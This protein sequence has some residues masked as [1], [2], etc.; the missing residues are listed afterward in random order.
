MPTD[1]R[2]AI[3]PYTKLAIELGPLV[4]FFVTQRR[5]DLIVATGVFMV[6]MTISVVAS[7]K[8]EKRW[9]V[10][11]VITLAFVLVLGALTLA[12]GEGTFI[13]V[14]PTF[15]N[16]TFA[17][18]LLGGLA[19]GK[20][21][22][23]IVFSEAFELSDEGWR[24]LTVRFGLFFVG[25][26]ILNEIVWRNFSDDGWTNFKVFG[27]IPLTLL[28]MLLQTPLLQRHAVRPEEA[29]GDGFGDGDP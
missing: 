16:L 8:L 1:E 6:A 5:W 4:A 9:P 7:R 10:M 12:L 27:I 15:T 11:P 20:L 21:F 29:S 26:A 18:V 14:K 3:N 25:L 28:F 2:P 13:K 17:A 19:R 22:L 24:K 23:K